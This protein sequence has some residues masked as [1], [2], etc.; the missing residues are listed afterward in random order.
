M[1]RII[2]QAI[3]YINENYKDIKYINDIV[4]FIQSSKG[5]II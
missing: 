4:N 3:N 1:L 2:S 5:Y